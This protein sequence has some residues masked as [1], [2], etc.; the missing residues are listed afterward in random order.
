MR[1]LRLFMLIAAA[2]LGAG[3]A[4]AARAT[5]RSE[6]VQFQSVSYTD[7]R[8]VFRRDATPAP[9]TIKA[10]LTF[11][12]TAAERYPAVV[13]VHTIG[14]YQ[15]AN[16]GWQAAQ[17][18][19]AGFATL[20]YDSFASRGMSEASVVALREGP[21]LA[22][23]VAD[24]YAALDMLAR[25]PRIDAERIAVL[26]F[27]F[28]GEV[29]HLAAF[30]RVRNA[31]A[32]GPRRFA[33]HVAYYPGGSY[34][35]APE[36]GAYTGAPILMLLGENDDN[37]PVAKMSGYLAYVSA[38]GHP[39]PIDLVIYPGAYHA[40]TASALRRTRFYPQ[41]VSTRKCPLILFGAGRP[42]MLVDGKE[43]PFDL[44]ALERCRAE[45]AGYTM[46]FDAPIRAK[47]TADAV[48]FLRRHLSP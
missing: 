16:E 29:A 33:A 18:R 32:P 4:G 14:G 15:E 34:G 20:T 35:T 19:Q 21:P 41:Y 2:V 42:T 48:A 12:D 31:I 24:A 46:G 22:S 8:Q 25:H 45:G 1:H 10:T 9:A 11:P 7:F 26:G 27:S 13:V 23:G 44:A 39:A 38:A 37:L 36:G 40:W 30:E 43:V 6:A 47:S 3:I 5:E 17:L 28:G